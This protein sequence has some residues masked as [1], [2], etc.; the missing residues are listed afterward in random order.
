MENRYEILDGLREIAVFFVDTVYTK[1][2][3]ELLLVMAILPLI[4]FCL[5]CF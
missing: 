3:W 5:K 4:L 1:N 2:M